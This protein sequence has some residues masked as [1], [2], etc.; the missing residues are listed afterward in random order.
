VKQSKPRTYNRLTEAQKEFLRDNY[1]VLSDKAIAELYG[2][3]SAAT[4]RKIRQL[5]GLKRGARVVKKFI[6][7]VPVVVW[8]PESPKS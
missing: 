8:I 3:N 6:D 5:M 4:V 7:E 2:W 1:L